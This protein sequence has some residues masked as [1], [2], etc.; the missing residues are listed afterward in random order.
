[1]YYYFRLTVLTLKS[2]LL[3]RPKVRWRKMVTFFSSILAPL[4]AMAP[5][6]PPPPR[7]IHPR[8]Y[9]PP[10]PRH[11]AG[12]VPPA[13]EAA[14]TQSILTYA[15]VSP[16][17]FDIDFGL[18]TASGS[19]LGMEYH[20]PFVGADGKQYTLTGIKHMPGDKC[21]GLLTQITTL[22]CHVQETPSNA[23]AGAILRTGIAKI[24]ATGNGNLTSF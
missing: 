11:C 15:S 20:L 23:S 9:P 5:N 4:V 8:Y 1:M 21:L 6:P 3:P 7:T 19:E 2:R 12:V 16:L 13:E 24:N 22:Y 17:G 14:L 10:P 18:W